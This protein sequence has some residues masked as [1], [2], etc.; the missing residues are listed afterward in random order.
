MNKQ[1][2]VALAALIA[3]C[4]FAFASTTASAAIACN[5]AGIVGTF[6]A[7]TLSTLTSGWSSI[8][9]IGHGRRANITDGANMPAAGIGT[10][11]PGKSSELTWLSGRIFP[12]RWGK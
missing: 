6:T 4:G 1:T 9:M 5:G 2:K 3:G 10:A 12:W 8:Q 7:I 11:I